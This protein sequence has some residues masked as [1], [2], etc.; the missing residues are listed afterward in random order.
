MIKNHVSKAML[1]FLL[2]IAAPAIADP[3]DLI[4][5]SEPYGGGIWTIEEDGSNLTEISDFGWFGEFSR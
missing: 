2:L 5:C 3:P 4:L 1:T